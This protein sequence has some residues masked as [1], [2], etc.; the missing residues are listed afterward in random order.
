MAAKAHKLMVFAHIGQEWLPCGQL[1]MTEE[2]TNVLASDFAYGT[3]YGRRPD[4]LEVDPV[5]LGLD[6]KSVV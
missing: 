3:R 1:Q 2:G 4:A 6:R 5:S